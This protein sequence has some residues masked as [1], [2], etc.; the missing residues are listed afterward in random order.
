MRHAE[1]SVPKPLVEVG[2]RPILWHVM[3]IYA[4]QGFTRFV[5]L[6]GHGSD[7]VERFA[8][9]LD[10]GWDVTCLQTGLET[11]TGGRVHR[12]ASLLGEGTFCLTYA[13]GVADIDLAG[14]MARHHDHGRAATMTVVRPNTQWGVANLEDDDRITGFTEKPKLESWING[15]FFVMEPAALER[16]GADDILEQAPLGALADRGDLFAYRHDGFWACMDT[17][18]D[19]LVLNELWD[20]GNAPWSGLVK[21]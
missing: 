17:Y 19:T 18:K 2:G 14:L 6:T 5:L 8:A 7:E 1:V 4:A 15:G 21:A 13:D 12:A 20:G 3:A 16:I 11:P 9:G 10:T